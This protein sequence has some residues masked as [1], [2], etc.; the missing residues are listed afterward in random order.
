MT[1]ISGCL[2]LESRVRE[3]NHGSWLLKH[4]LYAQGPG[5]LKE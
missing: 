5:F 4:R 2:G 3:T 1:G